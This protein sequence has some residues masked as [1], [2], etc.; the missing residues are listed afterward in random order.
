M[1]D[2]DA[3]AR[4]ARAARL[5]ARIARMT[6]G[7]RETTRPS[8]E[9]ANTGGQEPEPERRTPSANDFIR[10]RMGE[11]DKKRDERGGKPD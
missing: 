4:S 3:E 1:S 5:R 8:G 6:G 11:L 7:P 9:E 2:D 10:E